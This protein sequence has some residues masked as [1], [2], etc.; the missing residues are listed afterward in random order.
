MDKKISELVQVSVY[1]DTTCV[2]VSVW[3]GYNFVNKKLAV[4]D[5]T[6]F[7]N[8]TVES[9]KAYVI[10]GGTITGDNYTGD[11]MTLIGTVSAPTLSGNLLDVNNITT[12]NITAAS[13][14]KGLVLSGTTVSGI[15]GNFTNLTGSSINAGTIECGDIYSTGTLNS[16]M[17]ILCDGTIQGTDL[18]ISGSSQSYVIDDYNGVSTH[19]TLHV[20]RNVEPSLNKNILSIESNLGS[21]TPVAL[22]K[23][24]SIDLNKSVNLTGNINVSGNIIGNIETANININ[25]ISATTANISN[26]L[27][28]NLIDFVTASGETLTAHSINSNDIY[29]SNANI[30]NIFGTSISS[31]E[32]MFSPNFTGYTIQANTIN[33]TDFNGSKINCVSGDIENIVSDQIDA[34]TY[35]KGLLISGTTVDGNFVGK[36]NSNSVSGTNGKFTN[37][38]GE[39]ISGNFIGNINSNSVKGASISGTTIYSP[40]IIVDDLFSKIIINDEFIFSNS[41]ILPYIRLKNEGY[42]KIE[43]LNNE[44]PTNLNIMNIGISGGTETQILNNLTIG[45]NTNNNNLKIYGNLNLTG[46]I[47][48]P[49]INGTS[50]SGTTVSGIDGNFTNLTGGT[51]NGIFNGNVNS[52]LIKCNTLTN[53]NSTTGLTINSKDIF[54]SNSISSNTYGFNSYTNYIGCNSEEM[55]SSSNFRAKGNLKVG[56]NETMDKVLTVYGNTNGYGTINV[57]KNLTIGVD[58]TGIGGVVDGGD[59]KVFGNLIPFTGNTCGTATYPWANIYSKNAVIVT[60]DAR[61]KTEVSGFTQDEINA[62]KE[63]SKEI[64]IYKFLESI[65]E[66]GDDAR[67]HIGMTVQRAIGIMEKNNL[68]PLKYGFICYDEWKEEIKIDK[69]LVN[70]EYIDQEIITPA[71]NRYGFR[72][73]ELLMFIARGLNARIETLEAK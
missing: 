23:T 44:T 5:I 35:I 31:E 56:T 22:F 19:S 41:A 71:G 58:Y 50:L 30:D 47:T 65:K 64:G 9:I 61:L 62:S 72:Y 73:D 3:D 16:E 59:L 69:V 18:N 32:D 68:D 1:D 6:N 45:N 25:D 49:T 60:S 24:N 38:T 67:Y 14:V 34:T 33:S 66:K 8:V 43:R 53:I 39:T 11:D 40:N 4:K 2:P 63:L 26:K 28:S 46:S 70:D 20:Q 29:S 42:L 57:F 52:G 54:N 7:N 48:S 17:G 37:L 21:T 51:I 12:D 13:N 27:T 10:S 36:V 55:F 15:N